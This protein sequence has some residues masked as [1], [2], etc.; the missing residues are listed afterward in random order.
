MASEDCDALGISPSNNQIQK[1]GAGV[2][3]QDNESLPA[4]DL[5]RS[6]VHKKD[7]IQEQHISKSSRMYRW[8][9]IF[10]ALCLVFFKARIRGMGNANG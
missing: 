1:T 3:C 2:A 7:N 10:K 8:K 6:K 4:S 5:E 9:V